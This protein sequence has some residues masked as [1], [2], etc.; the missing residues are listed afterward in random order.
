METKSG[1]QILSGKCYLRTKPGYSGAAN[2]RDSNGE[3]YQFFNTSQF[4]RVQARATVL[5]HD[6]ANTSLE[7]ATW[8]F[9]KYTVKFSGKRV[10]SVI[11]RLKLPFLYSCKGDTPM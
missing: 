10:K 7:G 3:I 5:S 9:R 6:K 1:I 8:S 11:T 4:H 2:N